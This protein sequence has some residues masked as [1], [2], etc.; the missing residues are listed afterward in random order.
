MSEES[1]SAP[2]KQETEKRRIA[3]LERR[4]L[5]TK[6]PL[7]FWKAITLSFAHDLP[8][9][10]E[11]LNYIKT[12]AV[13]VFA[14]MQDVTGDDNDRTPKIS[15]MEAIERIPQA[16]QMTRRGWN[17]FQRLTVDDSKMRD[18][19]MFEANGILDRDPFK[20][21]PIPEKLTK[22]NASESKHMRAARYVRRRVNDGFNLLDRNEA[23]KG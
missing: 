18:T 12:T 13:L 16:L 19:W 17:A 10:L 22:E 14:L 20:N 1:T 15:P 6:N 4:A 8:L 9:S 5:A 21:I 2:L 7:Y 11:L 23:Q 3:S